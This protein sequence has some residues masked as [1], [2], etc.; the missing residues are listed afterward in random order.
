[1]DE[2]KRTPR[3][4]VVELR[5]YLLKPHAR[6]TLIDLFERE[7]VETQEDCGIR[8]LGTFRDLDDPDRF[9]W[10]RAFTDMEARREAL[11][12]FYVDGE[13]WRVHAPA[14]RETMVDTDNA[15][16][17]RPLGAEAEFAL[18]AG[19]PAVGATEPSASRYTATICHLKED[20]AFG[21]VFG[22]HV[23]PALANL[24]IDP[25]AWFETEPAPNTFERLPVRTGERLFVW[26]DVHT[27]QSPPPA[28]W[29][30]ALRPE[31]GKWVE[32]VETLRLA[33]TA[34][35]LLR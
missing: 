9:V 29:M 14:A 2:E 33:P 34:R 28:N 22:D 26:F 7:F 24:G 17:L 19:R 5:Q 13:A 27:Q 18:P 21:E 20:V 3:W 16:L 30:R 11:T 6:D 12:A 8:I 1:M 4:P 15:R 23:R 10:L 35:S 32:A 25:I 31:L